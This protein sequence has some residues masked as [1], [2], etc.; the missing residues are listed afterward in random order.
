MFEVVERIMRIDMPLLQK[1][2]RVIDRSLQ[3]LSK[4]PDAYSLSLVKRYCQL[5]FQP[6][7]TSC[8]NCSR[9]GLS[10]ASGISTVIFN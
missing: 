7:D 10:I 9:S 6:A 5:D 3:Q 4:L 2:L 1:A 8:P